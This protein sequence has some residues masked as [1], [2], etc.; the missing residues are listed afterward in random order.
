HV[1]FPVA[2][3]IEYVNGALH[4]E[5]HADDI[6]ASMIA[7]AKFHHGSPGELQVELFS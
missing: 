7:A 5:G 6:P 1:T 2:Q 3:V 4:Q